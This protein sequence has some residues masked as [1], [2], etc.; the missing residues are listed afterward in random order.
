MQQSIAIEHKITKHRKIKIKHLFKMFFIN[1][2]AN[3]HIYTSD[4]KCSKI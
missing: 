4:V 3:F 2:L 1:K